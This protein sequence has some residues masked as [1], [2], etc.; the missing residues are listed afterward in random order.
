MSFA[1][2]TPSGQSQRTCKATVGQTPVNRCTCPASLNFSSVVVA[3]AG[4]MNFPKR[5]PVLAKPQDGNSIR[6]VSS[7]LKILSLLLTSI[8]KSLF[9]VLK[10]RIAERH[11]ITLGRAKRV[12]GGVTLL[13]R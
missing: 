9:G 1:L 7:A 12:R 10:F 13:L 5:V 2:S 6:K 11:S 8:T 3:A 4:W